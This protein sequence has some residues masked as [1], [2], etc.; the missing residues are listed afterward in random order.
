[1]GNPTTQTRLYPVDNGWILK[2]RNYG[3]SAEVIAK[4]I[5][6]Y[7]HSKTLIKEGGLE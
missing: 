5:R 1:M 4:L 6:F 2:H 7:D 3:S